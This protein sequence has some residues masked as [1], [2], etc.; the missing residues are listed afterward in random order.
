MDAAVPGKDR[1]FM[2]IIGPS[3]GRVINIFHFYPLILAFNFPLIL[4]SGPE[5]AG[6]QTIFRL[7][8]AYEF[9]ILQFV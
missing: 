4:A 2:S 9:L 7:A 3:Y 1:R 6:Y 8:T 5:T